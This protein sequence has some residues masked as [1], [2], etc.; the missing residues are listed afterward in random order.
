MTVEQAKANA[1][2]PFRAEYYSLSG[3]CLS[4]LHNSLA[5]ARRLRTTLNHMV[6]LYIPAKVIQGTDVEL[7]PVKTADNAHISF[8]AHGMHWV[9]LYIQQGFVKLKVKAQSLDQSVTSSRVFL[10]FFLNPLM[11]ERK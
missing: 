5:K 8:N 11:L 4:S 6:F 3:L 7:P 9:T 10:N 2:E 1:E